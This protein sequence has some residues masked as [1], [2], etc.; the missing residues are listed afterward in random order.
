MTAPNDPR[1]Y[2]ITGAASGIGAATAALLAADGHNIISVDLHD[3]DVCVDLATTAG[4][5]QLVDDVRRVSDGRIDAVIAAAGTAAQGNTDIRVNYFG[6]VA[7]LD[8]LRPLLAAGTAPRAVA[9][10]SYAV[11]RPNSEE[12]VAACLDGDED[13][14]TQLNVEDPFVVYSST[15]RALARW[16][17]RQAITADWAGSDIALNAVAPGIIRTPM[18]AGLLASEAGSQRLA[19][20]VPMPYGG[21][22]DPLVVAHALA[23]L[24][25]PTAQSITGQTLFVDGGGDCV[26]RGDD[27]F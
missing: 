3:A 22:A 25:S 24:S 7:T 2:V 27:V 11:I 12:L 18:T 14:A 21:I 13:A 8:G 15:K 9:V 10:A 17:R 19:T 23:F 5:I 6:A 26:V 20:A 4:R 16:I 1:T